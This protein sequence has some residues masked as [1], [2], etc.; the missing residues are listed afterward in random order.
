MINSSF[1]REYKPCSHMISIIDRNL[2]KYLQFL[3]NIVLYSKVIKNFFMPI[4]SVFLCEQIM[5]KEEKDQKILMNKT[6]PY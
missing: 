4:L 2:I 3:K 1:R 6:R 5:K